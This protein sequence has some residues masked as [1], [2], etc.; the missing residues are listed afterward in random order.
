MA[1]PVLTAFA[2]LAAIAVVATG[3]VSLSIDLGGS[4]PVPMNAPSEGAASGFSDELVARVGVL[5]R[6][7][8]DGDAIDPS[9]VRS[10]PPD[11]RLGQSLRVVPPPGADPTAASQLAIWLV[12]TAS[13]SV[14]VTV[15]QAQGGEA[16]NPTQFDAAGLASGR[17]SALVGEQIFG[18]AP[19]G[20]DRVT[21]RDGAGR[22]TELPVNDNVFIGNFEGARPLITW[23]GMRGP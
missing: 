17:T 20:V 21:V 11:L 8:T 15:W 23:E 7:R 2:L 5:S 1:L 10:L 6:A 3:A 16:G 22:E 12:P 14:A 13:G 4:D 18:V 9:L 19:D